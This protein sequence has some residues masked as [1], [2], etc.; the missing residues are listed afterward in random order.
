MMA[1]SSGEA[2]R[3]GMVRQRADELFRRLRSEITQLP[4]GQQRTLAH[5]LDEL[6]V[7]L[8]LFH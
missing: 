5:D 1:K 3:A 4:A 8:V 2:T 6:Q 7:E